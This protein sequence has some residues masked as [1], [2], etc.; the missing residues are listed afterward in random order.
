M[1]K[2]SRNFENSNSRERCW[3]KE[4]LVS[5][6]PLHCNSNLENDYNHCFIGNHLKD[7]CNKKSFSRKSGSILLKDVTEKNRTALLEW[8]CEVKISESGLNKEICYHHEKMYLSRYESLQK[9]Y[10]D[11]YNTHGDHFVTIKWKIIFLEY[12]I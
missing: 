12:L 6:Q 4:R 7:E 2:A 10:C 11:P 3:K 1:E 5:R 9:Y 8:R